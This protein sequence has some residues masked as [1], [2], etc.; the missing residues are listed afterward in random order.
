MNADA[1]ESDQNKNKINVF[2]DDDTAEKW[3]KIHLFDKIIN[4][5]KVLLISRNNNMKKCWILNLTAQ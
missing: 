3:K 5:K 1:A 2:N 4:Q